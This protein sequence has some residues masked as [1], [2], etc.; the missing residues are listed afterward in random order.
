MDTPKGEKQ[1]SKLANK[2]TALTPSHYTKVEGGLWIKWIMGE[3]KGSDLIPT[4]KPSKMIKR[5]P[6]VHAL[7]FI[8]SGNLIGRDPHEQVGRWDNLNGWTAEYKA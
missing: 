3:I 7:L 6:K 8:K 4:H 5:I 2:P 1:M